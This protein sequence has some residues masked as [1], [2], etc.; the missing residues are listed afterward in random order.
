MK[1]ALFNDT[2]TARSRARKTKSIM[3]NWTLTP[4]SVGRRPCLGGLRS[5]ATGVGTGCHRGQPSKGGSPLLRNIVP[6][7]DYL[8]TRSHV[9]K[10]CKIEQDSKCCQLTKILTGHA[11]E[12][13]KKMRKQNNNSL[14]VVS[15]ISEMLDI[16]QQLSAQGVSK[17]PKRQKCH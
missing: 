5:V 3:L 6:L 13:G 12:N 1:T 14:K 8:T 4:R 10:M 15:I 7:R 17:C 16:P 9:S 11:I 2:P